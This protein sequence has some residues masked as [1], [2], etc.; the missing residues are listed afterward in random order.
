MGDNMKGADTTQLRKL[1]GVFS[2]QR[3]NLDTLVSAL[4]KAVEPSAEYWKGPRANRFREDWQQLRP[5]LAKFVDS[6]ER[7][8]KETNDAADANDRIND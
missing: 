2:T 6:L 5:T 7:A 1:S 3:E 8:R 4:T